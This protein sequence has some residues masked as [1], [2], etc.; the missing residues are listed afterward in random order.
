M[1]ER[2]P[3]LEVTSRSDPTTDSQKSPERSLKLKEPRHAHEKEGL[4][5]IVTDENLQK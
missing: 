5:G 2:H 4:R 1:T 3:L